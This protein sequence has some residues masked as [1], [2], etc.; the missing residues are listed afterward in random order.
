MGGY[1]A[2]ACFIVNYKNNCTNNYTNNYMNYT[3]GGANI[4]GVCSALVVCFSAIL[5]CCISI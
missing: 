4:M 1:S 3:D 5:S 2:L